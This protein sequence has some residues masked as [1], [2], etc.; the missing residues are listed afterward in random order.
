MAEGAGAGLMQQSGQDLASW[1]CFAYM[2]SARG[3][4]SWLCRTHQAHRVEEDI[5]LEVK[6]FEGGH[7]R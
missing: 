1:K 5:L 6:R 4:K 7:H 3:G 2:C